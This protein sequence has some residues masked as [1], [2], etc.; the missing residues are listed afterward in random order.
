[1]SPAPG[2]IPHRLR[3]S[4]LRT[5]CPTCATSC[6]VLGLLPERCP[7]CQHPT[8]TATRPTPAAGDTTP[9]CPGQLGLFA[10]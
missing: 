1:M 8:L 4:G 9:E 10:T 3:T 7:H 5:H 6:T 2:S